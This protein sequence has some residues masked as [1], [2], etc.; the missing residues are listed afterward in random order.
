VPVVSTAVGG[1]PEVVTDGENGLLVRA[2]D[3]EALAAA[4]RRILDEPGLRDQLAAAAKPSVEALSSD[5][6]YGK[7]EALLSEAVR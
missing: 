7:L 6:V 4:L 2:G 3:P 1:V 5:I